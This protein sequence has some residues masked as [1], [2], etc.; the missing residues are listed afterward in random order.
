MYRIND[1]TL[2]LKTTMD[3]IFVDIP[4]VFED[5]ALLG[6]SFTAIWA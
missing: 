5:D 3:D 2:G 4:C 1:F 6:A